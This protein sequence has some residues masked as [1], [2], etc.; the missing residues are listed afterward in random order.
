MVGVCCSVVVVRRLLLVVLCVVCRVRCLLLVVCGVLC[1]V[2]GYLV[3][4]VDCCI[5]V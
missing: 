4:D 1:V 5:Y 2:I 3:L